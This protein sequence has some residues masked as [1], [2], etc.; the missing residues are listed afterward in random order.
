MRIEITIKSKS[1]FKD[2]RFCFWLIPPGLWA[3]TGGL[4]NDQVGRR[5][6][7]TLL[8]TKEVCIID[9]SFDGSCTSTARHYLPALEVSTRVLPS[10]FA[11]GSE[12]SSN[13]DTETTCSCDKRSRSQSRAAQNSS[14]FMAC[15]Q[16]GLR[17]LLHRRRNDVHH[18]RSFL[19][20][21]FVSNAPVDNMLGKLFDTHEGGRES[22]RRRLK[23]YSF[24]SSCCCQW[25]RRR[26]RS[27]SSFVVV[28]NQFVK[29]PIAAMYHTVQMK[30]RISEG[31]RFHGQ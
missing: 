16:H 6:V 20:C 13:T 7:A 9:D 2:M 21:V 11:E 31:T 17:V 10:A 18:P 27:L 26:R 15:R 19:S 5:N 4:R 23:V 1:D 24:C 12:F 29:G 25:R 22:P 28:G 3:G 14:A 8:A 30:Q